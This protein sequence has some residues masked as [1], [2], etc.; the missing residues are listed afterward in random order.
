MSYRETA[1]RYA[2]KYGIDPGLYHALIQQESGWDPSAR[3][4]AGAEGLS[5]I[6]PDTGRDPG[7]G[8]RPVNINSTDDQ[9]RF[10]AEYF[11][12]ML[13]RYDGNVD[14]ALAAY[15][16]GAGHADDWSGNHAN[17]PEET[18]D[19][20][21]NITGS[22]RGQDYASSREIRDQE[23]TDRMAQDKPRKPGIGTK[24][25]GMSE[26]NSAKLGDAF[27]SMGAAT[28]SDSA[29]QTGM[30]SLL[31]GLEERREDQGG[32]FG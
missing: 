28:L 32:L 18:R 27:K 12:A 30:E 22:S 24:W 31:S 21:S 5:Q 7:F 13:D 19:Y 16:W 4:G 14:K 29:I 25:F 9:L 15:N 23:Q 3:S 17:L 10:G 26:E 2:E 11:S 6:M 20:I 8:V 1:T